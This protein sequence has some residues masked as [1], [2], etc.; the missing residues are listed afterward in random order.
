MRRRLRAALSAA[1]LALVIAGPAWAKGRKPPSFA[2][3]VDPSTVTAGR[4]LVVR[5]RVDAP[6][7]RPAASFHGRK[8]YFYPSLAAGQKREEARDW[9]TLVG[10]SSLE[11]PG[12][13]KLFFNAESRGGLV[14]RD[15]VTFQVEAGTY[16]VS[17]VVLSAQKDRLVAS[18]QMERDAKTLEHVYRPPESSERLWAGYFVMPTTGVVSSL[19]GARRAYGNRITQ[20]AHTGLDI[21]NVVGTPIAAPARGR[22]VFSRWLDSFGN[23]VVLDHGW[24]VFSYYLHMRKALVTE[25]QTVSPGDPLGEMG[26]EGVATGP[27]LHWS[28]AVGG[29]RVDPREWTERSVAP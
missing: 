21:A 11:E 5:C 26:Q 14:Y 20:T 12:D 7:Y 13:K 2:F 25:G 18:G 3:V 29:E 4:T 17:R 9:T 28:M 24:G 19:Y 16:P 15:T 27:H 6:I 1:F 22:V 10:I 23:A 8:T